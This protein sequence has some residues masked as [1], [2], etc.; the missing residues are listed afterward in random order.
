MHVFKAQNELG[1]YIPYPIAQSKYMHLPSELDTQI[2]KQTSLCNYGSK[3]SQQGLYVFRSEDLKTLRPEDL[4][5]KKPNN[6][7]HAVC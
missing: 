7:G 1:M 3:A 2:L 6:L 5:T 4:M